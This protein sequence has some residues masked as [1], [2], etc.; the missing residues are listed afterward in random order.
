M[1]TVKMSAGDL[2][3]RRIPGRPADDE[4]T[5]AVGAQQIA[6]RYTARQALC[7][8]RVES[9]RESAEHALDEG[10]GDVLR[11]GVGQG[12]PLEPGGG[13]GQVRGALALEIGHERDPVRP[14]PRS[15]CQSSDLVMADAQQSACRDEDPC[16]VEGRDQRQATAV[17]GGET[18]DRAA[19]I[20]DGQ[21]RGAEDGARGA[22]RDDDIARGDPESQRRRRIVPGPGSDEDPLVRAPGRLVGSE[23][24][25]KDDRRG[26][27]SGSVP[28]VAAWS[29]SGVVLSSVIAPTASR[30]SAPKAAR[31][32][33]PNAMR[34]RSRSYSPDEGSK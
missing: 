4:Q 24:T 13:I 15:Q 10:P 18:G 31:A 23:D 5:V 33:R 29:R 21:V 11:R 8:D 25:R 3:D 1:G 27:S 34:K 30:G 32:S 16:G 12:H 17:R 7:E 26:S 6:K 14:R 2:A 22:D 28:S 19:A 20:G 9:V